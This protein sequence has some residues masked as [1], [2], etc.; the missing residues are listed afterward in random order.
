MNKC[1]YCQTTEQQVKAGFTGAGSQMYKCKPCNRRYTPD[2]A[3][4]GYPNAI[5]RQAVRLHLEGMNYRRVARILQVSHV[6]VMNW[7]KA[8]AEQLP[9][10]PIP[11]AD[12]LDIVEMDELYTFVSR[13]KPMVH[14]HSGGTSEQL[15]CRLVREPKAR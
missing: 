14:N 13:K 2:P 15:Y 4:P 9:A 7:V 5:R 6:S 10:A 3:E 8:R 11:E 12:P 1:P